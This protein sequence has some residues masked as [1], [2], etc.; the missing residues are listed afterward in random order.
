MSHSATTVSIPAIPE[1][2]FLSAINLAVAGNAEFVPPFETEGILYIRPVVFGS[3]P[4]LMLSPPEEYTLVVYVQPGTNYHGVKP[5]D[6]LVMEDFDRAA[7]RGTG[8]AKVG[9]N[10]AP[11][12]R[13]QMKALRERFAMI[14]HLDSRT[15]SEIEEFSTSGFIGVLTDGDKITLVVTDSTNVIDSVTT[16][17]CLELAKSLQWA[18]ETRPVSLNFLFLYLQLILTAPLYHCP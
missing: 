3:S 8:N 12:I 18:V 1:D 6:G 14:L 13:H 15:R 7:P 5:L 11:V 10:Y 4:H 16:A 2:V 17:S 9:G